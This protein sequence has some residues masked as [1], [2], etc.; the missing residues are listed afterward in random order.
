MPDTIE[1]QTTATSTNEGEPII[2]FRNVTK[3][4]GD[5]TILDD[6]SFK[7]NRGEVTTIFGK[8]GMGK[9][10]ILKH[11]IGLMQPDSGSIIFDGMPLAEL[12]RAERRDVKSR[13]GYM[14]QNVALFDSMTV[15]DN[16]ALPLREKTQT[17]EK[18]IRTKVL[19]SLEKLEISGTAR[20]FPAEISGG[21]Q[22]RVGLA[23]ALIMAPEIILFDEPTTG[24]DP[25]RKNAV[26][27]MIEHMKRKF[28]F[29]AVIVSHEIPDVFLISQKIMM[30]DLGKMLIACSPDEIDNIKNPIVQDFIRGQETTKDD[31]TGLDNKLTIV[32][33]FDQEVKRPGGAQSQGS[34]IVFRANEFDVINERHG[35]AAG[36]RVMQHLGGFI[37]EFL[38]I[39]GDN[40]RFSDDLIVTMLP[41]TQAGMA[42]VLAKKVGN[43]LNEE[44]AVVCEDGDVPPY[45]LSAGVAVTTGRTKIDD[46]IASAIDEMSTIGKFE[47]ELTG[48]TV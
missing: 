38:R 42:R 32:H 15:Y 40:F 33:K 29:T 31:V 36:Q 8:S 5:L 22:K 41:N 26:H 16:I 23:R 43:A 25:V 19:D 48:E 28:G 30:L 3:S 27:S 6:I 20:K 10:V 47:P 9:S 21:M 35:F 37:E 18:E 7:I 34:M 39:S 13:I 4:F 14:F 1:K 12:G 24:L 17:S 2:E 11:I 45:I 44:K 46:V